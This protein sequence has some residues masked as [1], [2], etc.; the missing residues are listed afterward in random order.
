MV[1]DPGWGQAIRLHVFDTS[2][3][4]LW[5][6]SLSSQERAVPFRENRNIAIPGRPD[7]RIQNVFN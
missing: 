4:H 3:L 5:G 1:P 2:T 6:G 7:L